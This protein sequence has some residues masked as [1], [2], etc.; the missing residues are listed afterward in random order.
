MLRLKLL[1]QEK[2]IRRELKLYP[3]D[4]FSRSKLMRSQRDIWILNYFDNVIPDVTPISDDKVNLYFVVEEK[5]S[6][7]G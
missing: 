6:T 1:L 5:K 3:G 2:I 7:S 4:V